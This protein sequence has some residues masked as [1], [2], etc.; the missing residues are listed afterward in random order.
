IIADLINL[1]GFEKVYLF[2]VH[3]ET[4]TLLINNCTSVT[5]E[6]MVKAYNSVSES[7]LI[8]P[9]AGAAKKISHYF[10]WNKNIT[11]VVYC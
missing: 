6:I 4:A 8:C 5:N 3:S 2:D 11:D 9:D 7:I 1:C 10:E